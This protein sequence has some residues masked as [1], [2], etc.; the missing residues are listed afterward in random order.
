MLVVIPLEEPREVAPRLAQIDKP[1]RIERAPLVY[2]RRTFPLVT[3]RRPSQ[4]QLKM[5]LTPQ[6]LG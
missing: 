4:F 3:G 2:P 5:G 6:D 1:P